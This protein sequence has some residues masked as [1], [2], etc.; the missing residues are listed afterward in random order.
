MSIGPTENPPARA[1]SVKARRYPPADL[2]SCARWR[3][4]AITIARNIP[5]S[6]II[7]MHCHRLLVAADDDTTDQN[8]ARALKLHAASNPDFLKGRSGSLVMQILQALDD[9][10]VEFDEGC[11]VKAVDI[12]LLHGLAPSS[13]NPDQLHHANG[14]TSRRRPAMFQALPPDLPRLPSAGWRWAIWRRR[15][16]LFL[17]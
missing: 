10:G 8:T 15:K 6:L 9:A 14:R 7:G 16:A 2:M 12:D 3:M 17:W 13:P 4:Q 1:F 11:L 5:L